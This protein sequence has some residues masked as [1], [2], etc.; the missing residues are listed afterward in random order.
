[1]RILLGYHYYHYPV[2]V[3]ARVEAWLGRLRIAGI[4]VHPFCLTLCPPGPPLRWKELDARWRRGDRQL[5]S[6]Y[7]NLG[8]QMCSYDVFLNWNGINLHPEFVSQLPGF[9]VYACFDD[10]EQSEEFSKPVAASYDLCLVGNI[11]EVETYRRWGVHSARF[12]PLGFFETDYDHSVTEDLIFSKEK[13]IDILL[14]CERE[15]PWRSNRLD[16][17]AEAFPQGKYFGR[18]WPQGFLP[19][20]DRLPYY[21]RTKIGPNFHNST[22]PINFRT[23]ALPANGILQIC[24]NK[25]NLGE[26]YD[27]GK[28]AIGFD[29]VKEAIELTRYYLAHEE[30]R[31]EIAA[32]GWARAH[33]DYNE[34]AVFKLAEQYITESMQSKSK[35]SDIGRIGSV[36][37]RQRYKTVLP[38]VLHSIKNKIKVLKG[39]SLAFSQMEL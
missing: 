26:L 35:Q 29:T 36:L 16:E 13:D 27:L 15:N 23:Y 12:W 4:D 37:R 39:D 33:R 18:G 5:L 22:G 19:E 31:R 7:E 34:T 2:D 14:V 10:P 20:K 38:R 9:Q 3:K 30:E 11:A 8:E 28:E 24:D 1:M 32:A 21:R 25:K 17:Y 6:L